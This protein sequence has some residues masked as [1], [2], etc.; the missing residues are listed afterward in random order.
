[1]VE[2]QI[3]MHD[4]ESATA[5]DHDTL[6]DDNEA[7]TIRDGARTVKPKPQAM[8]KEVDVL[9]GREVVRHNA[10]VAGSLCFVVRRPG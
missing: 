4:S 6:G 9:R 8:V 1:M 5:E 3:E 2:L 7:E 10:G